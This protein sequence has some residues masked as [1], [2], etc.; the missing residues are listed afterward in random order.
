MGPFEGFSRSF[1]VSRRLPPY[2]MPLERGAACHDE[3]II[4]VPMNGCAD[5]PK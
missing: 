4:A 3:K 5:R 2:A 1:H